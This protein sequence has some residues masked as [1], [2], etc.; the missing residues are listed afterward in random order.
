MAAIILHKFTF[1]PIVR[2]GS[3]FSTLSPAF[4]VIR[5]FNMAILSGVRCHLIVVLIW[6]SFIICKGLY[7]KKMYY[8]LMFLWLN[9]I[10]RRNTLMF[11]RIARCRN[12][13]YLSS[14]ALVFFC[15]A[16]SCHHLVHQPI[17]VGNFNHIKL[18]LL[19]L[20]LML[21]QTT[22]VSKRDSGT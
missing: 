1:P 13:N 4:I 2:R 19:L 3:L 17:N 18:F 20:L 22:L 16:S 11:L 21:I 10:M 9:L 5:F 15:L 14:Q 7:I 6:I 12:N 8:L